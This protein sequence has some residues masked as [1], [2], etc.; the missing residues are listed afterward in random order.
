M[1]VKRPSLFVTVFAEKSDNFF[2]L[3]GTDTTGADLHGLD[4]TVVTATNLLQIRVPDGS[5][6]IMSV[7]DIVASHR[8]FPADFTFFRHGSFLLKVSTRISIIVIRAM[9]TF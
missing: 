1:A 4:G 3:I 7:A 5:G 2:N 6:L 8:F 9:Q